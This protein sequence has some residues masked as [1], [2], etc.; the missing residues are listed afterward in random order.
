[1]M[2][3]DE[4]MMA[5]LVDVFMM[6]CPMFA[7]GLGLLCDCMGWWKRA[8]ENPRLCICIAYALSYVP[9]SRRDV[10]GSFGVLWGRSRDDGA[11]V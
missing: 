9:V 7:D 11:G 3:D 8:G 10:A 6:R 5:A 4:M 1:M 2:I